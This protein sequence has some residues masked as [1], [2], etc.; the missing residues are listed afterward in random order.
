V[1]RHVGNVG[2]VQGRQMPTSADNVGNVRMS[3][4]TEGG[5][6]T[7]T[8]GPLDPT[9]HGAMCL[10]CR[11]QPGDPAKYM[12]AHH[13]ATMDTVPG[14]WGAP[15]CLDCLSRN[16]VAAIA[17]EL[18]RPGLFEEMHSRPTRGDQH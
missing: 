2:I 3:A 7:V 10:I 9:C 5:P 18:E 16:P 6:M 13:A 1:C 15:V 17:R 8:F 11:C 12:M 14:E 4:S